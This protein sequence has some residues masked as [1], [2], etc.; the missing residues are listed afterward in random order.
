M[1][2]MQMSIRLGAD[3]DRAT[4]HGHVSSCAERLAH[5]PG[6]IHA[7]CLY[8]EET[9]RYEPFYIWKD[10]GALRSFLF[11]DSFT[12]VVESCGRPRVR[13]WSV[14]EFDRTASAG[15]PTFAVREIDAIATGESLCR[16]ARREREHHRA[17]H[18]P[19]PAP[20]GPR[21]AGASPSGTLAPGIHAQASHRA[22]STI[23]L[24]SAPKSIP[25]TRACSG[26]SDSG[27]M[28]GWVLTSSM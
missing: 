1:L 22:S 5:G 16:V 10:N 20:P 25:A 12:E 18:A 17:Q 13:T 28:P 3:R 19:Q 9:Y 27:V 2:A 21:R 4:V 23:Q 7:S 15:S 6:L 8:D 24:T 11:G 26:T 14:L